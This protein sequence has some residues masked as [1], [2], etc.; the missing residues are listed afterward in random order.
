LDRKMGIKVVR[1][2]GW[3]E[4]W[5]DLPKK[6]SLH[7][8]G[9]ER[10]NIIAAV[11]LLDLYGPTQYPPHLPTA[12]ER[13]RW[14]TEEMEKRVAEDRFRMFFAIHEIEAW[15]LGDPGLFSEAV[16]RALPAKTGGPETVDFE[17][18]PAKLL[19]RLYL[20]K[21]RRRYR[22]VVDGSNLF[23]RL[24]PNLVY[25]RCPQFKK[26]MDELLALAEEAGPSHTDR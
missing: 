11:G 26:L 22:K 23:R 10:S 20:E 17:E 3:A 19:E 5:K 6:V 18:P 13:L 14:A 9:P 2:A 1:F 25:D 15:L 12:L 8:Q 16:R 24:Y 4:M 21:K 7:L